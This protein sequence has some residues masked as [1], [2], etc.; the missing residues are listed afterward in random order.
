MTVQELI[1][2]LQLRDPGDEVYFGGEG[3]APSAVESAWA[4]YPQ[5]DFPELPERVCLL[6]DV[7]V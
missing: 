5:P 3:K 6:T 4:Y 2:E 1:N 7:D